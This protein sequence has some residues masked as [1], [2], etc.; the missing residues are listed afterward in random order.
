MG[1][2]KILKNILTSNNRIF[3]YQ[4]WCL[5]SHKIKIKKSKICLIN[6]MIFNKVNIN[7]IYLRLLKHVRIIGIRKQ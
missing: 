6:Y 1:F 7:L 2:K 4:K 3:N 5:M